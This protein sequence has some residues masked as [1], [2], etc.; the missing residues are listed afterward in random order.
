MGGK[1]MRG[2]SVGMPVGVEVAVAMAVRAA[3]EE[4]VMRMCQR[5]LHHLYLRSLRES[6]SIY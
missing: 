6:I 3:A 1:M 4:E 5:G 2:M